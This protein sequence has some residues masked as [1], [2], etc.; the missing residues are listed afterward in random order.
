MRLLTLFILLSPAFFLSNAA[1]ENIRIK[2]LDGKVVIDGKLSEKVWQRKADIEK[3]YLYGSKPENFK[4]VQTSVYLAFDNKFIYFGVY[5][6][7]PFMKKLSLS[8]KKNDDPVWKDD[9]IE[10]FLY[11]SL[12]KSSYVQIV[13]NADGVIFDQL[14][15][16]SGTD[17][18]DLS[19]NSGA[20]CKTFKGKD[21]WSLEAAVP[22]ENLPLDAPEGDWKFH[23]ARNRAWK[24]E[25]Y[26]FVKGI[27]SFHNATLFF[28]LS[29]IRFP[30]LKL[31]VL[32]YDPGE[33]RYGKNRARIVLKNWSK[34]SVTATISAIG[35]KS[36]TL[37]APGT[38]VLHLDWEQ[39]FEAAECSQ[40]FIISEGKKVLRKLTLKR[41]LEALV[42]DEKN[43]VHFIES[44]QPVTLR[45]PVNMTDLSAAES[46]VRWRLRD[47]Q[48]NVMVSGMTQVKKQSVLLRI[49][50]SF[51]AP[52]NYKLE[53]ELFCQGEK[54][55]GVSRDLRFVNS[56][57]QG[58]YDL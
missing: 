9:G 39:P 58:I 5:C 11:P 51:M 18:H 56:P 23:I 2:P 37:I 52:G 46:Q 19:W 25:Q 17:G 55:A 21:F 42:S 45:I 30:S 50:W 36:D 29:G 22:L 35:V 43:A 44:N 26:S 33:C 24:N 54:V 15:R 53:L 16:E 13:F 47:L 4:P 34:K 1:A 57:F 49:F 41:K 8:G 20:V 31:T 27:D 7:E 6:Q 38:K 40:K 14:Q 32:D 3:F 28:T 48:G 12:R 10:L